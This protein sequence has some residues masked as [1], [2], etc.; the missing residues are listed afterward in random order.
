VSAP[1]K[2]QR[3]EQVA[4]GLAILRAAYPR[5]DISL[6]HGD[7]LQLVVAV[8]LSAQAT[9]ASV[10]KV[11]PALFARYRTAAD[12]AK[13][14]VRDLERLLRSIGLFR[15]KAKRLKALGQALEE[16]HGGKVP[17]TMQ[18]LLTLP[19]VARKTANVV[20]WN[21]F[22][23]NEGIAIDTH[24]GRVARRLGWTRQVDP[25]KV[26]RELMEL[27]PREDWG[28]V[29]HWLIAHGRAVC[30]APAPRCESCPLLALCPEG[31]RVLR[32]RERARKGRAR[33]KVDAPAGA[34]PRKA[35]R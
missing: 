28:R 6:A 34:G 20:L 26:E 25:V 2:A 31:P 29:T 32:A 15:T 10:D 22:R 8:A 4:Q 16:R 33:S 30:Q 11:T 7:P 14:D 24:A 3:R 13:A 5:A 12:Y 17:G 21:G 35:K 23:R 19:G 27:V 1:S 18:E 9:D